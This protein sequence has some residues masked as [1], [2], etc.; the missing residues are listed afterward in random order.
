MRSESVF[1]AVGELL[2][3]SLEILSCN[4]FILITDSWRN[5]MPMITPVISSEVWSAVDSYVVWTFLSGVG[6]ID[7]VNIWKSFVF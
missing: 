1:L 6:E 3:L 7:D 5:H 4:P 2:I